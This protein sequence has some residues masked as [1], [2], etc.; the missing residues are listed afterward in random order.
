MYNVLRSIAEGG[1]DK[2]CYEIVVVDNNCTDNTQEELE[3]FIGDYPDVS[4]KCVNETV[5]GL[6]SARNRGIRESDGDILIY[7]DDDATVNSEFL[8]SYAEFFCANPDVD[9]AGGPCIPHYEDGAEPDWMTYHLR[10][11]L[12]GYLYFGDREREFPG[13]N[14]PGGGN[15]GYRRKVFETV[16]LYNDELGRK[17]D[18]LTGGEEK[19]IF[20]KMK[21]A[22]MT[23][24]YIPGPVLYH[25]IP[26]YKL[27]ED[28]FNRLTCG[29]GDSERNRTLKVSR[30]AYVLRV[31]KEMVKWGGTLAL[32]VAYL[33]KG[34]P[35]C[36]NMLI[37]F[38]RNVTLHLLGWAT[39][40]Q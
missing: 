35:E 37:R 30:S 31:L 2:S 29:I 7:V 20:N 18:S 33:F 28:Y 6:S 25:S 9:A 3:R 19:D 4:L 16:G 27:E 26:H 8:S 40:R 11:L 15:A 13:E 36:G 32:W 23:F 1:Y 39:S 22:G 34:R 10:R 12:T 17:G 14:Y 38:R 24:R 5:Q 21:S